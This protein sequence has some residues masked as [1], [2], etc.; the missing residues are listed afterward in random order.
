MR[1]YAF[2]G[3]VLLGIYLIIAGLGLLGVGLPGF[4]D[5]IA[6]ICALVAGIIF[7]INR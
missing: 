5:M 3:Y 7:L 2:L 4:F 1:R 6:G